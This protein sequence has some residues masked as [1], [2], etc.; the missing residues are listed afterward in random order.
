VNKVIRE[1]AN[2]SLTTEAI[3]KPNKVDRLNLIQE[4]TNVIYATIDEY[5]VK[6]NDYKILYPHSWPSG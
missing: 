5:R 1:Y 6:R 4:R 3:K 2:A